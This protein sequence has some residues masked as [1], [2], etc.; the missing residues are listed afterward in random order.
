[1][2]LHQ[3]RVLRFIGVLQAIY[4]PTQKMSKLWPGAQLMNFAGEQ[5]RRYC[6]HY[7]YYYRREAFACKWRDKAEERARATV[8]AALLKWLLCFYWK[9]KAIKTL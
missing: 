6:L 5:R 4:T 2:V 9:N 3:S 1:M 8:R 7:H